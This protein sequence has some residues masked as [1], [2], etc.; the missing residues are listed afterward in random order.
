MNI[1]EKEREREKKKFKDLIYAKTEYSL[2][3]STSSSND[4]SGN[5]KSFY[6]LNILRNNELYEALKKND[7]IMLS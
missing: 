7:L 5:C 4:S 3:S 6:L 2:K 1:S